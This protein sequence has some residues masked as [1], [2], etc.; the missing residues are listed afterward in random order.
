ML[1]PVNSELHSKENRKATPES[2]QRLETG[3]EISGGSC[4]ISVQQDMDAVEWSVSENQKRLVFVIALRLHVLF[5]SH[6]QKLVYMGS[7]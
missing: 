5:W 2:E 4:C 3:R 1:L 7:L 6:V